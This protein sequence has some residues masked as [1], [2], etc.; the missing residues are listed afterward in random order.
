MTKLYYHKLLV[1]ALPLCFLLLKTTFLQGS[2]FLE[3]VPLTPGLTTSNFTLD[4]LT[5]KACFG[6]ANGSAYVVPSGGVAPYK[7]LWDMNAGT[8]TTDLVRNLRAGTYS[9]TVTDRND[10]RAVATI[11]IE[12]NPEILLSLSSTMASCASIANGSATVV[13]NGGS[14]GFTYR[15]SDPARQT[16]PTATG[17]ATGTYTVT[18]TD[19]IGCT[20]SATILVGT[21]INLKVSAQLFDATCFGR[22][23]GRIIASALGG[24]APYLYTIGGNTNS[25]GN[26]AGLGAGSHRLTVTDNQGCSK[27]TTFTL[28]QPIQLLAR[29]YNIHDGGCT[30]YEGKAV[31]Y[32]DGGVSPFTYRWSNQLTDTLIDG[33]TPGEYIVTVTDANGC[34]VLDSIEIEGFP[35]FIVTSG[36]TPNCS[37]QVTGDAFVSV[38]GGLPPY[39]V[40]WDAYTGHQR[41]D[42]ATNLSSGLYY[43]TVT[44]QQGCIKVGTVNVAVLPPLSLQTTITQTDCLGNSN[45]SATVLVTGGNPNYTFQ[46]SDPQAQRTQ[47]ATGLAP[48]TYF[49]TVMDQWGC[50]SSTSATVTTPPIFDI[51]VDVV[52]VSC[53]GKKDGWV[54]V[55]VTGGSPP[56]TYI[57]NSL[58]NNTGQFSDLDIGQYNLEVIDFAGCTMTETIE[59]T[60]AP[61]MEIFTQVLSNAGCTGVSGSALIMA[62]G[63]NPPYNYD[64]GGGI[65]GGAVYGL[66]A[67]DYHITVTDANGCSVIETLTIDPRAPILF[68]SDAT[69]TCFGESEGTAT[70]QAYNGVAPYSYRWGSSAL[71][72]VTPTA[73]NLPAGNHS[74]TI[75]DVEGCKTVT[76]VIVPG[77]PEI[78][79]AFQ[80]RGT[81]CQGNQNGSTSV[82]VNGGT[83]NFS[84]QWNDTGSSRTP[85]LNNLAPGNYSLTV[86][87][88]IGCQASGATE[89]TAP[90][91]LEITGFHIEDVLCFGLATGSAMVQI[92]GGNGNIRYQWDDSQR[93]TT[94]T[95]VNLSAG[96]YT[97]S[98]IDDA[99][100][101]ATRDV[102][103]TQPELLAATAQTNDVACHGQNSGSI[104]LEITGGIQ[105]YDIRWSNGAVTED[106]IDITAGN[107]AFTLTDAHGCRVQQQFEIKQ[108]P[109]LDLEMTKTD[110]NCFGYQN[111]S[112]RVTYDGGTPP[113]QLTWEGGYSGTELHSLSAGWY[114]LTITDNRGCEVVDSIEV[115]EPQPFTAQIIQEDV[116]CHGDEDG[117]IY[118]EPM[119]GTPPFTYSLNGSQPTSEYTYY[120]LGAGR[121]RIIITDRNNCQLDLAAIIEEPEALTLW[122]T[123]DTT[124]RLGDSV[125]LRTWAEGPG[126]LTYEWRTTLVENMSCTDCLSPTVKPQNTQAY[127]LVVTNDV[128]CRVTG[129]TTVFVDKTRRIYFPSA[130]SPNFDGLNDFFL[131]FADQTVNQLNYLRVFDRWGELIFE[132]NDFQPN[133]ENLGWD[134]SFRGQ[135]MDA[136]VFIYVAEV[137]FIDGVTEVFKGDVTLVR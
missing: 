123:G 120:N 88:A 134:G 97:V 65:V 89:V 35:P 50:F 29:A 95:A 48:G 44:D 101:T 30:G 10:D 133:I 106:L 126:F 33:L 129:R 99:G 70:V 47:T 41:G 11:V 115:I 34:Q 117:S 51:S 122:L 61:P 102:E 131:A 91:A 85:T 4:F 132:R 20:K 113:L 72:Q 111:G 78:I 108:T 76:T 63:G 119:G 24:S 32:V 3:N 105:P 53:F 17:L 62:D 40:L 127:D 79:L 86:T 67:K 92:D 104:E 96:T 90:V 71:G 114:E 52:P 42:T 38:T 112:V 73:I 100:C 15:W 81:D 27:D 16:T 46:W 87:D 80:T 43:F 82:S 58:T 74:V 124:I 109:S 98:L 107:Y 103:I 77:N 39:A 25:T 49:V 23:D 55:S 54:I 135:Q 12:E 5:T 118:V 6:E 130:F 56:Y 75:T 21:N 8:Q 64:W 125:V 84:Y 57:L 28:G 2:S 128:G 18:V 68:D 83:P 19:A 94:S 136:N 13:A 110:I 9:V 14:P 37:G 93:Q 66:S 137:E 69:I 7:Y 60:E 36:T 22:R 45:G 121:Y 59:I 1:T 31:V 26:F 116:T